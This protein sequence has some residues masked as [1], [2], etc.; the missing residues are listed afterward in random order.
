MRATFQFII[1]SFMLLLPFDFYIV[2]LIFFAFL[3]LLNIFKNFRR[4][5]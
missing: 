4:F 1:S 3:I 5:L 2:P